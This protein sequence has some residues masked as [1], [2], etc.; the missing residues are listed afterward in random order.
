MPRKIPPPLG[1]TLRFFRFAR[2]TSGEELAR[3][4]GLSSP[5]LIS[6]YEKGSKPLSR[7]R[8]EELLSPL[9]VP[10][11]AIDAALFSLELAGPGEAPPASPGEPTR[12]ERRSIGRAAARLGANAANAFRAGLTAAVRARRVEED[13]RRA[14]EVWDVLRQLTPRERRTVVDVAGEDLDWAVCERLCEES[15]K[16]GADKAERAVELA[17]LA[18]RVAEQIPGPESSQLQG[19]AWAF[20]GNARRIQGN[21]PDADEAFLRSARLWQEGEAVD[22]TPLNEARI[23]D[24]E[25]SLRQYQGRFEEAVVLLDRALATGPSGESLGRL[26]VKKANVLEIMGQHENAVEVLQEA[27]RSLATGTPLRIVFALRFNLVVNLSLLERYAEAQKLLPDVRELALRL[28]NGLDLLRTLWLEGRVWAGLG[29]REE[30]M[31]ALE[32]VRGDLTSQEIAYDAALVSLELAVLRLEEGRARQV[33]EMAAQ[34]LWIFRAQGVHREALA[35]LRLFHE[36]AEHETAT[37]EMAR[38]VL[39]YLEKARYA[40]ELPFEG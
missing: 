26:L 19:Y 12:E 31:T 38:R 40:P 11:E 2:G 22:P 13:R 3:A 4:A 36:A 10:P 23:F 30:A 27:A 28:A 9:D 25:A 39:G 29:R 6:E 33:K 1:A 16:A 35:A 20:V 37:V 7:E 15:A 32:Q 14:G 17:G 21:L 5:S 34:M 24:L 18:L 8:L